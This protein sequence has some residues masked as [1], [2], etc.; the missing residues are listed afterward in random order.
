MSTSQDIVTYSISLYSL[1]PAMQ[2]PAGVNITV[3]PASDF[4]DAAAVALLGALVSA[5]PSSLDVH[6]SINKSETVQ[7]IWDT[8]TTVTPPSF[9]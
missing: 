4:D 5:F 6:G 3:S 2:Q 9:T 1:G 8:D 7:T